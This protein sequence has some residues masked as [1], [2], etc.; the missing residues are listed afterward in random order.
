MDGLRVCDTMISH[1]QVWEALRV[2]H[3]DGKFAVTEVAR[4]LSRAY[5]NHCARTAFISAV[6]SAFE[7]VETPDALQL[8]DLILKDDIEDSV[9]RRLAAARGN[10]SMRSYYR[11]RNRAIARIT[12]HLN[13]LL[14]HHDASELVVFSEEASPPPKERES[15]PLFDDVRSSYQRNR[16]SGDI[17]RMQDDL[18][19]LIGYRER[20]ADAESMELRLMEA[21]IAI[22]VGNIAQGASELRTLF[23]DLAVRGSRRLRSAAVVMQATLSFC[24][25]RV[26]ETQRL[27]KS[28]IHAFP[29]EPSACSAATV[30]AARAGVLSGNL[31]S[32]DERKF[33]AD[34]YDDFYIR[35]VDAR[36]TL[37]HGNYSAACERSRDIFQAAQS[38]G[39]PAAAA[40]S[41]A[42][43]AF[44]HGAANPVSRDEWAVTALKLFASCGSTRDVAAD[45][46][47]F[48][49]IEAPQFLLTNAPNTALAELY[50]CFEPASPLN[51]VAAFRDLTADLIHAVITQ[52]AH[53]R[54]SIEVARR[55]IELAGEAS[56]QSGGSAPVAKELGSL[57][58]FGEFLKVLAPAARQGIYGRR[59]SSSAGIIVRTVT[60]ELSR[61]SLRALS[62]VS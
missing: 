1:Q 20:L 31:S 28:I 3:H 26:H 7:C 9:P 29:A 16:S 40:Y 4:R 48:G 35:A 24:M 43:M 36:R 46:F 32:D 33:V 42:T 53:G 51:S 47:Q 52:T 34:Q 62:L 10:T 44:C 13:H 56:R 14:E 50:Q 2:F 61:R 12:E 39:M 41:A 59:F 25:G 27:A 11:K 22:R 55:L 23:E 17:F 18:A 54:I 57:S 8:R 19:R 45:L 49:R 60:R 58:R 6:S 21:E 38:S 30:L 37:L 5:P 15:S